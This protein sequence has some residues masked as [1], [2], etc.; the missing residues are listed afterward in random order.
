M[1]VT[2]KEH[3]MDQASQPG[4][5]P[6]GS[7]GS[8]PRDT[9]AA[10]GGSPFHLYKPGQGVH[11]RWG[12]AAGLGLMTVAFG[13]FLYDQLTVFDNFAVK[14]LVPVGIMAVVALLIFRYLAQNH[15]VV[16]FLIATEG[17]MKKVNWTSRKE[18][19]GSTKVVIA[20]LLMMA[21]LLFV[22]DIVFMLFFTWAGILKGQEVLESLKGI[23]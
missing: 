13:N 18:I 2:V 17:E 19:I 21:S 22:V 8:A 14:S 1:S 15:R 10:P 6:R 3:E 20:V 16:D 11:V 12:T 23:F 5:E 4:N 7:R 9:K